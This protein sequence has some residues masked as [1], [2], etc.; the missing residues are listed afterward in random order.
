MSDFETWFSQA[1]G[2]TLDIVSEGSEGVADEIQDYGE[3]FEQMEL[4]RITA[5]DP[6][7][8]QYFK[9]SKTAK[10]T[11]TARKKAAGGRH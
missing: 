2:D 5:E 1:Y 11:R 3:Q 9:A 7:S 4:E 6:D 10:K 8:V